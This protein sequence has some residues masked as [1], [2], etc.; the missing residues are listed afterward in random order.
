MSNNFCDDEQ[1]SN[2]ERLVGPISRGLEEIYFDDSSAGR[3]QFYSIF[4]P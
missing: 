1:G 2:I 3:G 4:K